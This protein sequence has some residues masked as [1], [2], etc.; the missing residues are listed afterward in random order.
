MKKF[1]I[2]TTIILLSAKVYCDDFINQKLNEQDEL[3]DNIETQIINMTQTISFLKLDNN[4]LNEHARE[5]EINKNKITQE[6][7]SLK[8]INTELHTALNSN[9]EDTHEVINILGNITE[10]ISKINKQKE[11]A[12]KFIQIIIPTTT[13]PLIASGAY[14]Y[15]GTDEKALGKTLIYCGGGLLIGGELI[16]NGGKF[17]LKIW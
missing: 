6:I 11:L 15:F 7:S 4:N 14:L 1:L 2:F 12:D 9:K 10:E 8:N 3:I 17:I 5:L 16:W 13:I